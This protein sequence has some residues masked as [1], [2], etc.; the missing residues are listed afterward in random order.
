[1]LKILFITFIVLVCVCEVVV[2]QESLA[3]FCELS[4]Q[5]VD[6][7]ERLLSSV[8]VD[9]PNTVA[10]ISLG[11][12]AIKDT[13]DSIENF[14]NTPNDITTRALK[15]GLGNVTAVTLNLIRRR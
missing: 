10:I 2:A 3:V 5:Y 8:K 14:K 12:Q 13:R 15:T 4:T 11:K 1:M 6:G 9:N 7:C